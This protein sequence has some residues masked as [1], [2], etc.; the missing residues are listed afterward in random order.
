MFGLSRV[1]RANGN[2]ARLQINWT[3]EHM[4]SF[5]ESLYTA[6]LRIQQKQIYVWNHIMLAYY[7]VRQ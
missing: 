3:V 5:M 6:V 7:I 2:S 1:E 4:L